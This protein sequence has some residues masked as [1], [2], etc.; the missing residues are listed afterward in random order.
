MFKQFGLSTGFTMGNIEPTAYYLHC[1]EYLVPMEFNYRISEMEPS[2]VDAM[3]VAESATFFN[4]VK[5][6]VK[7]ALSGNERATA[8]YFAGLQVRR[9]RRGVRLREARR[10]N[11]EDR[12]AKL[13]SAQDAE[14]AA[15]A[16]VDSANGM[17]KDAVAE[18]RSKLEGL[19]RVTEA[20]GGA[21]RDI[22]NTGYD[23]T[24]TK[25]L[26]D[27]ELYNAIGIECSGCSK[28]PRALPSQHRLGCSHRTA[29]ATSEANVEADEKGDMDRSNGEWGIGVVAAGAWSIHQDARL[30]ATIRHCGEPSAKK[31]PKKKGE[32]TWKIISSIGFYGSRSHVQCKQRWQKVLDPSLHGGHFTVAEDDFIRKMVEEGG[33]PAVRGIWSAIGDQMPMRRTDKAV[34]LR[35][36]T[37]L[38]PSLAD[39]PWTTEEDETIVNMRNENHGWSAIA[40][41]ITVRRSY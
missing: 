20:A 29:A 7:D 28:G 33:G 39:V 41:S 9:R 34:R 22:E 19:V 1:A 18:A 25:A 3:T 5:R 14:A 27:N 32:V 36:Y 23:G 30:I 35:W 12:S 17:D 13:A 37:H 4:A 6:E 31:G 26:W 21:L 11:I 40:A 2:V 16:A 10:E 38:D 15:R 8:D 24:L